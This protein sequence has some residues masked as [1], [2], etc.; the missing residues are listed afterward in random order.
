MP[1]GRTKKRW[2][3]AL[4][5]AVGLPQR[6]QLYAEEAQYMER[7]RKQGTSQ[8][9]F[10]PINITNVMPAQPPKASTPCSVPAMPE[11]TGLLSRDRSAQLE[12]LGLRDIAVKR[13]SDWQCSQVGDEALKMEYRK[14]WEVTLAD[15]LDLEQ[16]Y[17]D[18][19][20]GFYIEKG[21]KR[22]IARRFVSDI[23]T[24]V[25]GQGY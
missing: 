17:N 9:G 15:G 25:K 2:R 19:D 20:A 24:W 10:P 18:Q 22:G 13:Y 7:Q 11:S 1:N 14:A 6:E 16:V 12:I 3:K 4:I 5:Y 23:V 8:A 21:V